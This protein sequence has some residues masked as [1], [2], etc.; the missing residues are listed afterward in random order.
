MGPYES[1]HDKRE[2]CRR[3]LKFTKS[4]IEELRPKIW[5]LKSLPDPGKEADYMFRYLLAGYNVYR[6]FAVLQRNPI[7]IDDAYLKTTFSMNYLD[8]RQC[9]GFITSADIDHLCSR[10]I[11]RVAVVFN[12]KKLNTL[13][14]L[15][16][17]VNKGFQSLLL[18]V[19]EKLDKMKTNKCVKFC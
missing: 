16:M 13:Y 17:K 14:F 6:K 12:A 2:N 10:L 9:Q 18:R 7:Q 4:L 1:I 3:S 15:S 5:R 11:A 19:V 8:Y